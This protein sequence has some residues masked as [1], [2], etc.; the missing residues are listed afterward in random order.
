MN[1]KSGPGG[2][3][4]RK[5][6]NTSLEPIPRFDQWEYQQILEKGVRPLA[7]H[8][9]YQVARILIDAVASMIRLGMHPEDFEKGGTRTI[10][11]SGAAGWI[12]R[13]ETIRM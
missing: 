4:T 10:L 6:G 2:K 3:K 13:I 12:S 5:P 9:P 7:E 11:K 1:R 8:E